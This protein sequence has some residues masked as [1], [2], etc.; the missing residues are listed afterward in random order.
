MFGD[1]RENDAR[2]VVKGWG[3]ILSQQLGLDVDPES[4]IYR[5]V[6]EVGRALAEG[7]TDAV[8]MTVREFWSLPSCTN[9]VERLMIGMVGETGTEEYV[10]LVRQD[11]SFQRLSDLRD[12]VILTYEHPRMSAAEAWLE[13]ALAAEVD[14]R[15]EEPR[16][17]IL[18]ERKLAKVVLPLFFRKA[19]ACLVNRKGFATMCEMNPQLRR[20]LRELVVSPPLL[21]MGFFFRRGFA[22]NDA[23]RMINAFYRL[24]ETPA[25]QQVLQ[26]FQCTKVREEPMDALQTTLA[27]FD[28]HHLLMGGAG[29]QTAKEVRP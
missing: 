1:I 15:R 26:V 16:P 20:D 9:L 24:P 17:V 4:R 11:A 18:R 7:E 23:D 19:D 28:R 25:G 2:A 27:L 3:V 10:I 5:S 21:P 13:V 8:S 6:D 22:R 29:T 14:D 12:K